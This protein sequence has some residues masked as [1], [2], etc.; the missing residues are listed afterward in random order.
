MALIVPNYPQLQ[1][2]DGWTKEL[3]ARILSGENPKGGNKLYNE[4]EKIVGGL[5]DEALATNPLILGEVVKI[6]LM[7]RDPPVSK[8]FDQNVTNARIVEF[9]RFK[10]EVSPSSIATRKT[11]ARGRALTRTKHLNTLH[12][13]GEGFS[14]DW[15]FHKTAEGRE[16][17]NLK[18]RGVGAD[19]DAA[20]LWRMER[21]ICNCEIHHNEPAMRAQGLDFPHR[22]EDVYRNRRIQ[23]GIL[24]KSEY[25]LTDMFR[26]AN[27]VLSQGNRPGAKLCVTTD[28]LLLNAIHRNPLLLTFSA[29][30]DSAMANQRTWRLPDKFNGL[31]IYTF[32]SVGSAYHDKTTEHTL[33]HPITTGTTFVFTDETHKIDANDYRSHMRNVKVVDNETNG[34]HTYRLVD[35]C[36]SAIEFVPIDSGKPEAGFID[37]AVMN[38]FILACDSS[39]IDNVWTRQKVEPNDENKK[40][41]HPF[42]RYVQDAGG[43]KKFVKVTYFGEMSKEIVDDEHFERAYVTMKNALFKDF[44]ENELETLAQVD[45]KPEDWKE[46][47]EDKS[48]CIK[49]KLN[50]RLFELTHGE[51]DESKVNKDLEVGGDVSLIRRLEKIG[52]FDDVLLR[53]AAYVYLTQPICL[54]VIEKWTNENVMILLMGRNSRP[55]EMYVAES[56]V[57]TNGQKLGVFDWSDFDVWST[58]DARYKQFFVQTDIAY[59][60]SITNPENMYHMFSVRFSGCFGG[61]GWKQFSMHK[62]AGRDPETKLRAVANG[63]SWFFNFMS[64]NDGV[65]HRNNKSKNVIPLSGVYHPEQFQT[66]MHN[67]SVDFAGQYKEPYYS[68]Q[69]M[70]AALGW[71]LPVDQ[72]GGKTMTSVITFTEYARNR[73]MNAHCCEASSLKWCPINGEVYNEGFHVLGEQLPKMRE[74]ESGRISLQ[75]IINQQN[76]TNVF[77]KARIEYQ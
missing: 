31:E 71:F 48:E 37:E 32:P 24:N 68:G 36:K 23:W 46:K 70:F 58:W 30:G 55:Y 10:M 64:Y 41:V 67:S 59:G 25:G 7:K 77:K 47:A 4:N 65:G 51:Y 6:L 2:I 39:K 72:A 28:N 56:V 17:A 15:Y 38:A 61:K 45:E 18:V 19:L 54:Q 12:F 5:I 11:L 53:F 35:C 49:S 62:Y 69:Y 29:S 16:E 13:T 3:S 60:F 43:D 57:F 73:Y 8:F 42:V 20:I 1:S 63:E 40:T 52:T 44:T 9:S 26:N 75:S 66:E 34:W 76:E 21:D 50:L 27:A 74:R 33:T 14:L 22:V